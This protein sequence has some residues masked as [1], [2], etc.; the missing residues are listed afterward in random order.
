MGQPMVGPTA[1]RNREGSPTPP[2]ASCVGR[3]SRCREVSEE[4]A[5]A[6]EGLGAR[7]KRVGQAMGRTGR[8][9]VGLNWQILLT[10]Q[11]YSN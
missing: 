4:E 1:G 7:R 5:R 11:N 8:I 6:V 3:L 10:R 2:L 9:R